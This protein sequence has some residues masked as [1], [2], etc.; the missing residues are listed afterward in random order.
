MFRYGNKVRSEASR[1]M[2]AGERVE[3][4]AGEAL[5]EGV[6]PWGSRIDVRGSS[7]GGTTPVA[8]G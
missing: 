7:V 1:R 5:H 6:L 3:K 4:V 2:L 8:D